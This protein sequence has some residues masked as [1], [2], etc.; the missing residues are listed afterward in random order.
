VGALCR[1]VERFPAALADAGL[2]AIEA[3]HRRAQL[4]H[5][6]P[7]LLAAV[8]AVIA[9]CPDPLGRYKAVRALGA[10]AD[11]EATASIRECLDSPDKMVR[12]A[13]V[14]SVAAWAAPAAADLLAG[15]LGVEGDEDVL[16]AIRDAVNERA[17]SAA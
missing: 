12:L 9:N 11:D 5:A 10:F 17:R 2:D 15:R 4:T 16:A 8:R 7:M 14:E 13:A 6:P 3:I 1:L